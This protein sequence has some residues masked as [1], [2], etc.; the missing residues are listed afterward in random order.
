MSAEPNIEHSYVSAWRAYRW[1]VALLVCLAFGG[2][3]L[4]PVIPVPRGIDLWGVLWLGLMG[5]LAVRLSVFRCPRCLRRYFFNG[6]HNP[7]A[8]RCMHCGL[9]KWSKTPIPIERVRSDRG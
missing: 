9:P 8:G 2:F 6:Y 5:V 3:V 4:L 1:T 7:L